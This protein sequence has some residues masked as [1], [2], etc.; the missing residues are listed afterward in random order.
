MMRFRQPYRTRLRPYL[1]GINE[2]ACSTLVV[3][4]VVVYTLDCV[5]MAYE[6]RIREQDFLCKICR[7]SVPLWTCIFPVYSHLPYSA[8]DMNA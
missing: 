4:D 6:L 5:C 3:V 1:C 7:R 2:S 8:G